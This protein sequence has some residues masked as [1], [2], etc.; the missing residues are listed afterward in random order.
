MGHKGQGDLHPKHP[1][2]IGRW[3]L[4]LTRV[5]SLGGGRPWDPEG[6]HSLSQDPPRGC[7]R[8]VHPPIPP[9]PPTAPLRSQEGR[10]SQALAH[11][12]TLVCQGEVPKGTGGPPQS[13]AGG[14]PLRNYSSP[15]CLHTQ[16]AYTYMYSTHRRHNPHAHIMNMHSGHTHTPQASHST[17][18][19]NHTPESPEVRH[20]RAGTGF[21][22][23]TT[24]SMKGGATVKNARMMGHYGL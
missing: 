20:R 21:P 15:E 5:R 19:R 4:G 16:N 18:T 11:L 7:S 23:S 17:Y 6:P 12:C 22:T 9:T 14:A 2:R 1:S 8:N 3:S 24:Q 13:R 10:V